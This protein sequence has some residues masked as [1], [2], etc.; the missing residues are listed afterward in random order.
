MNSCELRLRD[1]F[2]HS[3]NDGTHL[4]A[5]GYSISTG[6]FAAEF[7]DDNGSTTL[8][9]GAYDGSLSARS[10]SEGYHLAKNNYSFDALQ[11]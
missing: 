1:S 8:L 11:A 4:L 5:T 7:S 3:V 2:E 6:P 10:L 9:A